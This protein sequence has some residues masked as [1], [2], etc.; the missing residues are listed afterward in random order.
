MN[1]RNAAKGSGLYLCMCACLGVRKSKYVRFLGNCVQVT[2]TVASRLGRIGINNCVGHS[3]LHT[4]IFKMHEFCMIGWR[5][6]RGA[7]ILTKKVNFSTLFIVLQLTRYSELGSCSSRWIFLDSRT[8]RI[9]KDRPCPLCLKWIGTQISPKF[10]SSLYG[11][12]FIS[13]FPPNYLIRQPLCLWLF[14]SFT[15]SLCHL[16]TISCSQP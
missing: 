4:R 12:S 7:A 11:E 13:K 3:S 5:E 15:I 14:L 16:R 6:H 10:V 1:W 9:R 2:I 8:N